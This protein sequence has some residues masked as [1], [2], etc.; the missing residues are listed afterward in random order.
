MEHSEHLRLNNLQREVR[1]ET[2]LSRRRSADPFDGENALGYYSVMA[3]KK[4][5]EMLETRLEEMMRCIDPRP[6]K[7]W[8]PEARQQLIATLSVL[9]R[10]YIK[11]DNNSQASVVDC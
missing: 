6:K 8:T 5:F 3:T 11:L 1:A 2:D 9:Q 4:E 7:A 10:L